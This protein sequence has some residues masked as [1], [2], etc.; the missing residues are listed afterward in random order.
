MCRWCS[1]SQNI[2]QLPMLKN[3]HVWSGSILP[4][5]H[6]LNIHV[7]VY[8]VQYIQEFVYDYLDEL[9]ILLNIIPCVML[10]DLHAAKLVPFH[11]T[12]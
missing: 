6:L 5:I 4:Q 10:C 7:Y 1:L 3:F 12:L 2:T 8:I 9:L 11:S